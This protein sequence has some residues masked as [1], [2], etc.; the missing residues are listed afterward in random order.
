MALTKSH[1][2]A[3][4]RPWLAAGLLTIAFD[5][6]IFRLLFRQADALAFAHLT[7]F[8][9]AAAIGGLTIA[10]WPASGKAENAGSTRSRSGALLTFAVMAGLLVFLRGGLLA[11]LLQVAALPATAAIVISAIF[12]SALLY[13]AYFYSSRDRDCF[14]LAVVGFA[15]LLRLFYLG[16]P[17]LIF[18]EAYYWNYAQHLDIGY[19]DHP[20]MVAW[21]IKAFIS[22]MGSI[23]FAVRSGAFLCWFVTAY[24]MYKLTLEIFDRATARRALVLVAVLPPFFFFGLLMSPDAPL[25]A[26][27]AMAI[28]FAHQALVRENRKAWLGVG[29]ALGLGMISK[30]TIALLG[31]AIVLFVLADRNSRK[32]LFRPDP[33]IALAVALLL[34]SPVVIWNMQHDWA[35]FTFQ[36][37]GRVASSHSFS[38]PRFIGNVLVFLTPAGLLSLAA[39]LFYRQILLA[40]APANRS[41]PGRPEQSYRLLLLL[42]LFPVLVFAALSLFRASKLNWTGPCWLGLLPFMALLITPKPDSGMPR[43]IRCCQRAWPATIVILLAIYGAGLHYWG[44]GFPKIPYTRNVHLAG[45]Q[46]FGHDIEMLVARLERETGEEI[47]V[48]GMDR[49][50]IASEL[51]FYRS[52]YL[53]SVGAD[54]ATHNPALQTASGHLFGIGSLMYEMWFPVEKQNGKTMLL[55][56]DDKDDLSDEDVL[57]R[58][59]PVSDIQEIE[60]WKNGK[61]TGHYYYRLVKD[62]QSRSAANRPAADSSTD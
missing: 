55:V 29:I 41:A 36:S 46:G 2:A 53:E 48:V 56:S 38:L 13:T 1:L 9:L 31:V 32:W 49:N 44:L 22:L 34:F 16:I 59:Q 52:K 33:Y 10:L 35:S 60:T 50:Q 39:I 3:D 25:T 40:G 51:A 27:W 42:T 15:V 47:L 37:Q 21:I 12:S 26:C 14:F 28:Y 17:N 6:V 7:S 18:E 43:V 45:W 23:E 30:Y 4:K 19:L 54:S 62:Y 8:L 24:F 58:A 20:L 5:V 11:S 61:S 57:S